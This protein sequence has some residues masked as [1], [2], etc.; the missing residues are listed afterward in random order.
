MRKLL[1]CMLLLLAAVPA[2]AQGPAVVQGRVTTVQSG[3]QPEAG[4]LVRIESM[5]AG[6]TT[7]ADGRYRLVV[8]ASRVRPGETVTITASRHGLA[9]V[10]RS[11]VLVPDSIVSL[12][13][14]L[15][16]QLILMEDV[17]VSGT[18]R[19]RES[20]GGYDGTPERPGAG[21]PG[22]PGGE[23]GLL[24]AGILEDFQGNGWSRYR[25][26]LRRE[27]RD[28]GQAWGVQPG[29]VVRIRFRGG[30]RVLRDHAVT[31][32][33]DGRSFKVRTDADGMVRLFPALAHHRLRPG[34]FTVTPDGGTPRRLRYSPDRL[35][36]SGR[37][38][39]LDVSQ[40]V[41]QA[42][43]VAQAA[44]RPVLDIGFMIDATGSMQDELHFLQTELRDIIARVQPRRAELDVRISIVFYRDRGD[45]F[46]T[47]VQAFGDDVDATVAFL[48]ST[49]A[50]GGGDTPEEMNEAFRVMMS[51][52]WSREPA[53]RMLFVL[54]DAPPHEYP[55]AR[56]TYHDALADASRNGIAI[57]PLAASG[58]DRPTEYLMRAM[59]VATGGKY[60]FLTDDSGV[61]NPHLTPDE[62]FRVE[63][64]NDLMVREIRNFAAGY[65]PQLGRLP[66]RPVAVRR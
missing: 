34:E 13:F 24:T 29:E 66:D 37:S 60:I 46:V 48:A 19:A 33:Q 25:H 65:F 62:D 58:I 44:P 11:I 52:E 47:R 21:R 61:G 64:L 7:A 51:Q 27:G 56:Y 49:A 17:V 14:Q 12:D 54:A 22:R 28:A 3:L 8:P 4:V 55:D 2:A 6:A 18:A 41:R 36:H 9:S 30:R 42:Q 16:A 10:S 50:R 26:F 39:V 1:V 40:P 38:R 45:E 63:R 57:F 53:A 35:R 5:N 23:A 32:Q 31:V 59:A 20:G 15:T 43:P